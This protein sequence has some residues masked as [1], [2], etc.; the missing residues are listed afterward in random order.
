MPGDPSTQLDGVSDDDT[1]LFRRSVGPIKRLAHERPLAGSARPK[2]SPHRR[3]LAPAVAEEFELSDVGEPL[4][5]G[6]LLEFRRP[7][8][9][10]RQMLRLRQ[11]RA[12]VEGELDLHGKTAEQARR[13]LPRFLSAAQANGWRCVRV[14]HG[15]GYRSSGDRPVLKTLVNGWLQQCPEVL[16]Y[17]SALPKDGGTGAVYVLLRGPSRDAGNG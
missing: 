13:Q 17:C 12:A 9:Q 10:N 5:G 4:A 3:A 16:A 1:Q 6:D 8:L 14:I 2:P 11:G 15:K 7:G